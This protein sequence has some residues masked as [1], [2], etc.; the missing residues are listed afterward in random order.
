L[1]D[2]DTNV[3]YAD[4][5]ITNIN[6]VLDN[7]LKQTS[8]WFK[9]NKLSWNINKT[10]T[11]GLEVRRVQVTKFLGVLIDEKLSPSNYINILMLF[12]KMS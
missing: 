8:Q 9:V 6:N 7:E 1:F 5:S 11:D 3:I 4:K 2:D 12:V 10:K